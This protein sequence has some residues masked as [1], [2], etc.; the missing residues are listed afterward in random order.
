[1]LVQSNY[2]WS[3]AI[4]DGTAGSGDFVI[5]QNV[6]CRA[7]EKGDSQFDARHAFTANAVYSVPAVRNWLVSGWTVSGSAI[8]RT[9]LPFTPVI[10][11]RS[12]T[13]PDGNAANQRPDF[14]PGV[15][16][17]PPGGRTV[18]LWFN[19]AAFALPASGVWGNAGRNI[20]RGPG[21][22][23]VDT[24]VSRRF[25]LTEQVDLSLRVEAFNILNRPQL[26]Q[27]SANVSAT[28][29]GQITA[30]LNTGATGSGTPR[31]FQ[32]ALRLAF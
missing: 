6:S 16:L 24:A 15:S 22:F 30:R 2:T 27:P 11:R 8:A 32:F 5:P 26:G 9:G 25:R 7:C 14:V 28:N 10:T 31:Q 3:H 18:D 4:N 29:P 1:L 23:Q 13:L 19:P 20:L 17:I 12:T 21:V